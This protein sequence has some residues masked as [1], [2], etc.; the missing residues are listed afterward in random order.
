MWWR[1]A[2]AVAPWRVRPGSDAVERGAAPQ[3]QRA[4]FGSREQAFDQ[5]M[6]IRSVVEVDEVGH[7]VRDGGAA[8]MFGAR[9]R[10]Q[11]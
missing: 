2:N 11:L 8:D 7:F 6:E 3:P 9:I 5:S 10:R 4:G 1:C